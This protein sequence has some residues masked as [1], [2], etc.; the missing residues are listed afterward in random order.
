[1]DTKANLST[2]YAAYAPIKPQI[3]KTGIDGPKVTTNAR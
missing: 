1:M 2:N 3:Y